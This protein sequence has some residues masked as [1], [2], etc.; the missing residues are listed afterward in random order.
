[1]A[2][3][4]QYHFHN[5]ELQ[6]SHT[7]STNVS[8]RTNIWTFKPFEGGGQNGKKK[9]THSQTLAGAK[10]SHMV[11]VLVRKGQTIHIKI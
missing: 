4:G 6:E 3:P 5:D 11:A 1:M 10:I 2:I 9:I 7:N 8:S